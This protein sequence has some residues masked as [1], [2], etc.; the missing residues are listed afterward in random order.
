MGPEMRRAIHTATPATASADSTNVSRNVQPHGGAPGGGP[1]ETFSQ[2]PSCRAMEG[3]EPM[4]L[5]AAGAVE[6]IVML[7]LVIVVVEI[8]PVFRLVIAFVPPPQRSHPY[9]I[10][11]D[12]KRPSEI[13]RDPDSPSPGTHFIDLRGL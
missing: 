9:A 10:C 11:V 7:V 3:R 8:P 2:R 4:P 12:A 5:P 13:G 6:M 1:T